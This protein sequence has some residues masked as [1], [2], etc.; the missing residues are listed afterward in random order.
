MFRRLLE[1]SLIVV[2][3]FTAQFCFAHRV[4]VFAYV[5][6]GQ[7]MV[8]GNFAGG[9]AAMNSTVTASYPDGTEVFKG[10]T[11]KEGKVSFPIP[12]DPKS[13]HL[14]IVLNAGEGHRA[15][16][17]LNLNDNASEASLVELPIS[18]PE[19]N[20]LNKEDPALAK[21]YTE[22]DMHSALLANQFKL[23][24]E[25]VG[26]LRRQLAMSQEKTISFGDVVGGVGWLV[27]IAGILAW[28]QSRRKKK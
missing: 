14:Q 3:L 5:E 7:V 6:G 18:A 17:T 11:N 21:K 25:V 20:I 16:W 8:E 2:C 27:G 22:A 9:G 13:D 10:E 23:E 1:L 24:Q 28:Y 15:E 19:E 26:P 4:N 12:A